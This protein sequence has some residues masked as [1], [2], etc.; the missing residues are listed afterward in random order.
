MRKEWDL[1]FKWIA[2]EAFSSQ[3]DVEI[4]EEKP[5]GRHPFRVDVFAHVKNP[6]HIPQYRGFLGPLVRRWRRLN[7]LEFKS[8][9]DQV[10]VGTVKRVV[11]HFGY[12]GEKYKVKWKVW[13]QELTGQVILTHG[14][15]KVLD[16]LKNGGVEIISTE[17][18]IYEFMDPWPLVVIDLQALELTIETAPLILLAGKERF[19]EAL[20]FAFEHFEKLNIFISPAYWIYPEKVKAMSEAKQVV[21]EP[22][23]KKAIEL[24]GLARVIEEVGLARVIEEV[25]LARVIEEVGLARVIEEVGLEKVLHELVENQHWLEQLVKTGKLTPEEQQTLIRLLK[26]AQK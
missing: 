21:F 5:L 22:Q 20:E 23:I 14:I 4:E 18:G 15:K 2:T 3:K 7:F 10:H 25:G 16:D 13:R 6:A 26:K 8:L 19:N 17:K 12:Y 9:T 11:G 24:L 1:F